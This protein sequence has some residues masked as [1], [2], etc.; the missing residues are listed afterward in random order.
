MDE[1]I[2]RAFNNDYYMAK[3]FRPFPPVNWVGFCDF[4]ASVLVTYS[5]L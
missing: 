3:R 4:V 1:P 5:F 2:G